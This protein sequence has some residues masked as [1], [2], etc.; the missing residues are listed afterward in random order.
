MTTHY[1]SLNFHLGEEIDMLRDMTH[2]FAQDEIAPRAAQIDID[3]L[4]PNDLWQKFGSLGLLG[5]TVEEEYGGSN[6]GY[7]AHC[8]AMEE[9]SRASASVGDPGGPGGQTTPGGT[10]GQ[11]V[12]I[13]CQTGALVPGQ[14]VVGGQ[15]VD[16][17]I[18]Y[19]F[20]VFF[21]GD[22]EDETSA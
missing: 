19:V 4:F 16:A 17:I 10:D 12:E 11:V 13:D 22:G 6:M 1:S 15:I 3:N 20:P 14:V 2:Q 21:D 7:L 9:I 8:V 18:D 5:I